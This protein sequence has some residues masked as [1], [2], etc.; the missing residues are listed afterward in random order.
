M[1]EKNKQ[2]CFEVRRWMKIACISACLL[3]ISFAV[4]TTVDGAEGF[5]QFWRGVFSLISGAG[6]IVA[7]MVAIYFAIDD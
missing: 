1:V 4:A 6:G 3:F 5:Y 2:V 7:G